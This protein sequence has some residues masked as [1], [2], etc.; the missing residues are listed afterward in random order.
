MA[1]IERPRPSEEPEEGDF[2]SQELEAAQGEV[3]AL[4]REQIQPGDQAGLAAYTERFEEANRKY[5]EATKKWLDHV[6]RLVRGE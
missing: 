4:L 3:E 5:N 6:R 1:G 2:I